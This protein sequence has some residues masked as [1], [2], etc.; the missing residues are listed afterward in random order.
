M[1]TPNEWHTSGQRIAYRGIQLF[2]NV[3]GDGAPVLVLHGFPTSSY[4]FTRVIPLLSD[5]YR[6]ILFDYPGFGFSDKPR[7]FNYSLFEYADAAQ[8][9]AAH[10][11]LE[12]VLMFT[13]DIGDSVGLE[14]LRRGTPVVEKLVMMNGSVFS[15]PLDDIKMLMMQRLLLHHFTGPLIS[16]LR[17]FRKSVFASTFNKIFGQPLPGEDIDAFWSLLQYN[18]GVGVYHQLIGYMRER[19]QHQQEWLDTL[20]SHCEPLT[21]IWGQADPVATPEVADII[22]QRRSD[23]TDIR[24]EG[25]GHYPHWEAPRRV[26]AAVREA[27][28]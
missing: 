10:F 28:G 7:Q 4:D 5:R 17:L 20:Q 15:I 18:D 27:F 19:W 9:V 23:A 6:L 26:A 14:L 8:T 2:V 3:C 24:L 12:R 11:G 16:K 21:V 25:I 1:L 13:H 22:R